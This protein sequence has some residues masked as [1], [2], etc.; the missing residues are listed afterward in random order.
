MLMTFDDDLDFARSAEHMIRDVL[1]VS[2][3]PDT[4]LNASK[5]YAELKAYDLHNAA[6]T[7]EVKH[8]RMAKDTGN[9]FLEISCNGIASGVQGTEA[10]YWVFVIHEGAWAIPVIKLKEIMER[11][12]DKGT[13][14]N[15]SGDGGRVAGVTFPIGWMKDNFKKIVRA[16]KSFSTD[17]VYSIF[18]NQ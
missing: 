18:D 10:D 9:I 11:D 5:D 12:R 16:D 15:M 6:F 2:G 8:D 17:K 4:E 13:L 1:K 14:R 7:C 3:W